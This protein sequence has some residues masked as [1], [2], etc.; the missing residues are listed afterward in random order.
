MCCRQECVAINLANQT[1]REGRLS[2]A[3]RDSADRYCASF[4]GFRLVP[5][6]FH[7]Q[8]GATNYARCGWLLEEF[9]GRGREGEEARCM[10]GD[11]EQGWGC[12][13]IGW[14]GSVGRGGRVCLPLYQCHQ[15]GRVGRHVELA[16][17]QCCACIALLVGLH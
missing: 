9:G 6:D 14:V 12:E 4:G 8:C 5:F 10:A 13:G 1:G 16:S 17:A 15:E 2:S 3:Y 7:K 11:T